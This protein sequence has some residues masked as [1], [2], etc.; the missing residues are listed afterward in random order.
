MK[1]GL[2]LPHAGRQVDIRL[3]VVQQA[4]RLGYDSVW[5]AELYGSDAFGPLAFLA[6]QTRS[7]KLCTGLVQISARTP[8]ACA[9]AAA[10]LDQLAGGGRVILG[11]GVSGPQIVEGWYGQPWRSPVAQLRSYVTVVRGLLN[12]EPSDFDHPE[13]ALPHRGA[14]GVGQGRPLK[15]LLHPPAK[16]PLYIG[17]S[18]TAGC[19]WDSPPTTG[20]SMSHIS[21]P[22][23][24]AASV[25]SPISPST[26]R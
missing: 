12:R 3:E 26:V 17:C 21:R 24:T 20:M 13:F 2:A 23:P 7:I 4:E 5:T 6:G 18:L 19:L 11:L 22:A 1:L 8:A 15:L 25:P 10:T 16:I 9:M 14:D